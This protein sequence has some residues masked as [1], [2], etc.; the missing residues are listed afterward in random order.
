MPGIIDTDGFFMDGLPSVWAPVQWEQTEAER[1]HEVE[2]QA[3]ASL[4]A[5]ADVPETILR[6]LLN[7]TAAEQV[8][9]PPPGYNPSQQGEWDPDTITFAFRRPVRLL[10]VEREPDRLTAEYDFGDFGHWL[11]E[12]TSE[13][14]TIEKV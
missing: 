5:V 6:L 2:T 4:L 8:Y 12:I 10:Q 11:F 7:E 3:A 1:A 13:K 9:D 14:V